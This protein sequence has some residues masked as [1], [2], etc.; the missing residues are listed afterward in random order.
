MGVG[1]TRRDAIR[2][3]A[4][5]VALGHLQRQSRR[6]KTNIYKPQV[7]APCDQG[8]GTLPPDDGGKTTTLTPEYRTPDLTYRWA[9]RGRK[10][11]FR[12]RTKERTE[13]LSREEWAALERLSKLN[14]DGR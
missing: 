9:F 10:N 12:G 3:V 13:R 2:A 14:G 4:D 8:G 1:I 11:F 6:R 7:V 5:L